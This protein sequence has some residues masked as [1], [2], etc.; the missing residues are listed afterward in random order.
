[1]DTKIYHV[2]PF[3][4]MISMLFMIFAIVCVFLFI[5]LTPSILQ[6][7]NSLFMIFVFLVIIFLT[8]FIVYAALL[9]SDIPMIRLELS[10]EGMVLY[11]NGYRIYTPWENIIGYA[12]LR[13]SRT[14]PDII[15][16]QEPAV[17]GEISFEEGIASRRAVSE[18]R[19][20]WISNRQL[21]VKGQYPDYIRLPVVLLRRKDKQDGSIN[22]YLQ[23][24]LPHLVENS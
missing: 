9:F 24:Y 14:F 16:L 22:Q 21:K 13:S 3:T 12:W 7:D 4:W 19:R 11:S 15:Q 20:W 1:M 23:Y 6:I 10:E 8:L 5:M 2:S 18:K 17:V